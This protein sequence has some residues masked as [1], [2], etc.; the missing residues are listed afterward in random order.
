M[1]PGLSGMRGQAAEAE[2]VRAEIAAPQTGREPRPKTKPETKTT[3]AAG[4]PRSGIRSNVEMVLDALREGPKRADQIA[5]WMRQHGKADYT[6]KKAGV[7]LAYMRAT[8]GN[9]KIDRATR[10]WSLDGP[11]AKVTAHA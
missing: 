6:P 4:T 10:L 9:V 11:S 3:P 8:H 2:V 5:Q 7:A 1:L